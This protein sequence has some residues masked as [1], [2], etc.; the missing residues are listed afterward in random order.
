MLPDG[1]LIS[2]FHYILSSHSWEIRNFERFPAQQVYAHQVL[3]IAVPGY[4][5]YLAPGKYLVL[6]Y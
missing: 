5:L 6:Y 1:H 3:G 4:I 2:K